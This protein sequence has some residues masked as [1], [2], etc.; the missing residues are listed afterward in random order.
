MTIL[1]KR[2]YVKKA[3]V[4]LILMILVSLNKD[5]SEPIIFT[6]DSGFLVQHAGD[7]QKELYSKTLILEKG[8]YQVK[9]AYTSSEEG[10]TL[11]IRNHD[12]QIDNAKIPVG[13][14]ELCYD[15]RVDEPTPDLEVSVHYAGKGYLELKSFTLETAQPWH[16]DSWVRG[17]LVLAAGFVILLLDVLACMGKISERMSLE[18]FFILGIAVLSSSFLL[19]QNSVGHGDDLTY[20]LTRIEGIAQGLR[21]GQFPV[22]IYPDM[23]LGNGYLNAM[24]P[25]LFL[26]I[27]A[28]FRL[29]GV[30]Y[31]VSYKLFL[32]FINFAA[33][34]AMYAAIKCFSKSGRAAVLGTALYVFARYRLNNI[35]VRGALGE[36]LA[37]IFL[38]LVIAGVWQIAAG[39]RRKWWIL[40]IGATGVIQSHVLS[41]VIYAAIA[42]VLVCSCAGKIVRERRIVELTKA[43]GLTL[44]VNMGFLVPFLTYYVKGNLNLGVLTETFAYWVESLNPAYLFG[45]FRITEDDAGFVR[46]FELHLPLL[47]L[48]GFG[49]IYCV[50]N[51]SG[52]SERDRFL[53]KL[54]V[55]AWILLF[56]TTNWFPYE[57]IRD[58]AFLDSFFSMLQFPW[59]LEGPA[60]GILAITG[61]VWLV[62]YSAMERYCNAVVIA[63][64]AMVLLDVSHWN[65]QWSQSMTG[66]GTDVDRTCADIIYCPEEYMV[67]GDGVFYGGYIVSDEQVEVQTYEKD[68]LKIDMTYKAAPGAHWIDLPLMHYMGYSV[69][70]E[71]G[72]NY[73]VMTADA[74][75]IKVL[76][77]NTEWHEIHVQYREPVLFRFAV[78]ISAGGCFM[79]VIAAVLRRRGCILVL[80]VKHG[81]R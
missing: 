44:L 11:W 80:G 73:D 42:F 48:L 36:S 16:R 58:V 13:E 70:N 3:L 60:I 64:I 29:M 4:I 30:S 68:G 6:G 43:I 38:P 51:R 34:F 21:A 76:I 75:N 23:L 1:Q 66:A 35:L 77:E 41:T 49:L 22:R 72:E 39:D 54:F 8:N 27:P 61:A 74:G 55:L 24:Y 59:R 40:V 78:Y 71:K 18:I 17:M 31:V 56:I 9:L 10:N 57:K 15:L 28:V 2:T 62:E 20:H 52:V 12:V 65:L 7:T 47:S 63:M 37:M 79:A 19:N 69:T 14:G 53:R 25:S 67:R 50:H 46:D 5:S 26:Y 32:I 33:A 81:E 45:I